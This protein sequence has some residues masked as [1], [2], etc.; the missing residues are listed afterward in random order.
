MTWFSALQEPLPPAVEAVRLPEGTV[1][2]GR[3]RI[4]EGGFANGLELVY[5]AWDLQKEERTALSEF[6]PMRW[7]LRSE[8]GAWVPYHAA[9]GEAF[10][11]V[12]SG[13]LCR[14][15]QLQ[16]WGEESALL[17]TADVFE[18]EGT[19][20]T[21]TASFEGERL[22]SVMASRLFTPEE[23]ISLLA[24]VL[25]TL[26]G[27]HQR[28]L[29][30]GCITP[31]T[32][33]LCG[34]RT[35]LT[36]WCSCMSTDSHDCDAISDVRSMSRILYRMLTGE[37]CWR[38]ETASALPRGLRRALQMGM[39]GTLPDIPALWAML[40]ADRPASRRRKVL[41]GNRSRSVERWMQP[42][43]AVCFAVLCCLVPLSLFLLTMGSGT[44]EDS[45]YAL[46]EGEICV[47]ELLYL[48]QEEA[49]SRAEALG[50]RVI[51]SAREDNP[52][53]PENQVVTQSPCAGAVLHE[54]ETITIAVSD[55]WSNYVPNVCNLLLED[56]VTVL[57]EE[58]FLVTYEEV[59][60]TDNAPGTVISQSVSPET[61]LQRDSVIHLVVS[62]GREDLDT[63]QLEQ[64]GDYTGMDF[65][66]AKALLAG[67]HL[68]ALQA[69]T[70]YDPEV[71]AGVILSQDIQPG[72]KVPQGTVINMVVS[73]GV[74]K[75]RVPSVS[76]MNASA[77]KSALENAGLKPVLVYMAGSSYARD[78]V[79]SQNLAEGTL[80]PI[81]SEVWL[82][83]SLG[84]D[85]Y[86]ISTG[87]WSGNALPG[88]DPTEAPTAAS[89]EGTAPAATEELPS[90]TESFV[91]GTDSTDAREEETSEEMTAPSDAPATDPIETA[92][93]SAEETD[94]TEEV[95][96]SPS[97][98]EPE[99]PTAAEPAS[100]APLPQ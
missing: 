61:K 57:E 68:Y 1:I 87:G 62:L 98:T 96:P 63:S 6:L 10:T 90:E 11:A 25:D 22:A 94:P 71:P 66:E 85:S 49:F 44:L 33:L 51:V 76:L 41:P 82:T 13:L 83:V 86:V 91:P 47:P 55:G 32:I 59:W 48:S 40:H 81:G 36:G 77:A 79:I 8:E 9:A 60:S 72:Q 67:L 54:G 3:Y 28:G 53:V 37:E 27:L 93:P 16:H 99:D 70:V 19:V 43:F 69:E 50:L 78:C 2:A 30:H 34:K 42:R 21:V 52:V 95:P 24:P 64:V 89:T 39:A 74:E 92:E 45:A 17:P 23:A 26:A 35:Y 4:E 58:G 20:W 75:V 65:E 73:L 14:L 80:V 29:Y 7:C 38:R 15:E 12:K 97:E 18:A 5:E 100:E 31:R 56:A 88:S 84:K 46:A